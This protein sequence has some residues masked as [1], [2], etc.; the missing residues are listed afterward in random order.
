MPDA[1]PLACAALHGAA[2]AQWLHHQAAHARHRIA[3]Y[4][5]RLAAV[6]TSPCAPLAPIYRA[7][8]AAPDRRVTCLLLTPGHPHPDR[9]ESINA[10]AAIAFAS[11][12]WRIQYLR[13]R[14]A[15]AAR[16]YLFDARAAAIGDHDLLNSHLENNDLATLTICEPDCI[17]ELAS[18]FDSQW[19]KSSPRRP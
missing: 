8:F 12:G 7:L 9:H 4:V 1:H 2:W 10:S 15:P 11:H 16:C 6:P 5:H 17:A 3:F 13:H 14:P 19:R 18:A